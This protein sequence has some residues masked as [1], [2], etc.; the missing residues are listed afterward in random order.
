MQHGLRRIAVASVPVERSATFV[1]IT[2]ATIGAAAAFLRYPG[3]AVPFWTFHAASLLFTWLATRPPSRYG[4]LAIAAFFALGFWV[5]LLVHLTTGAS[6]VEPIGLFDGSAAQWDRA[7]W[8]TAAALLG[9]SAARALDLWW[10]RRFAAS[11]DAIVPRV[12]ALFA[13]HRIAVWLLSAIVIVGIIIGNLFGAF[14]MIGVNM[15]ILLPMRL[16]VLIAFWLLFGCS[17]WIALLLSWERALRGPLAPTWILV[18]AAEA[19]L[20]S[21]SMLSRSVYLF[22]LFPYL[23]VLM[24]RPDIIRRPSPLRAAAG[25][26]LLAGGLVLSVGA[27]MFT[28]TWVY[29][30]AKMP[31]L[32]TTVAKKGEAARTPGASDD[33][34]PATPGTAAA[35]DAAAKASS[36]SALRSGHESGSE[37]QPAPDARTTSGE[38]MPRAN[39]GDGP[40]DP[41]PA[42][43]AAR[44]A[45][46]SAEER[47]QSLRSQ[48]HQI[49]SLVLARWVGLEGVLA[50]TSHANRGERLFR[51]MVTED[52]AH[53]VDSVYQRVSRSAYTR[54]PGFTFLTLA[55]VVG[56]LASS[57][58]ALIA[59]LGLFIVIAALTMLDELALRATG[60]ALVAA[61][62][63]VGAANIIAQM[64]FPYN[65]AVLYSELVVMLIVLGVIVHALPAHAASS[66]ST[67]L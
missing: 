3:S 2:L 62:V 65:T 13:R 29:P 22:R 32:E 66:P 53:G 31:P 19:L 28:R 67:R 55:G 41:L 25:A 64:N 30:T 5:K 14:A 17:A 59:A 16:H 34:P 61:S 52:P 15:R 40:A 35:P 36:G 8:L 20:A 43:Q 45:P 47:E 39:S 54:Q 26:V 21:I 50:T 60:S 48:R 23:L 10:L 58:S 37:P 42:T 44:S 49:P 11:H 56:I 46:K 27:S 1:L 12:P 4:V 33:A 57:G 63:G 18:A 51:A 24:T 9:G 38:A 6:F 7:L